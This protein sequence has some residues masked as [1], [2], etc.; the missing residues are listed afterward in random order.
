MTLLYLYITIFTAYFIALSASVFKSTNKIRDKYTS[1]D[2]NLCVVIYASGDCANL[3]IL[4][5][6]IKN[7]TYPQRS[8]STYVILDKCVNVSEVTLQTEQNVNIIN[9]NNL[10]PVGKSQA[11]SIIAEKLQDIKN[12][13]AYVFLDS[14][15][16]PY[17]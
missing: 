17:T 16:F 1:K 8:Y 3:E 6:Q 11:Y 7:Q 13:D 14:K 15:K 9:I 5:N 2:A 4:I 12:L 10:E